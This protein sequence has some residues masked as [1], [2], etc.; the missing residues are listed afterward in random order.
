MQTEW[1]LFILALSNALYLFPQKPI[2]LFYGMIAIQ[3]FQLFLVWLLAQRSITNLRSK[4]FWAAYVISRVL[5]CFRGPILEDDYFRYL[6]DGQVLNLGINPYLYAPIDVHL[7]SVVS[8]WRDR[9]NFPKVKT[10][11]PPVAQIYFAI[12]FLSFGE[13]I[14]G[15]RV[16]AVILELAV[17]CCLSLLCKR[18][19]RDQMPVLLFLFFPT[20]M[21][22]N[23]NSIHFDLLAT[24]FYLGAVLLII[25]D[26]RRFEIK[27]WIALGLS[28]LAKLFPL[29]LVPIFMKA[30]KQ[31][32]KAIAVLMIVIVAAYLPFL[33]AS[34]SLFSGTGAF[35]QN[36]IFFD[37]AHTA[38]QMILAQA[39]TIHWIPDSVSYDW[40][41]SGLVARVLC[42][43]SLLS[44]TIWLFFRRTV[45]AEQLAVATENILR[46][47]TALIMML[48][49]FSSVVNTWY[50]LWILPGM[51]LIAPR[52]TW[53]L[54]VLTTLGY[55]WFVSQ[56][57]YQKLHLP[58]YGIILFAAAMATHG[59]RA[60][61]PN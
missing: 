55:S 2:D 49:V 21:K 24:L 58:F 41:E 40:L 54:P 5:I 33:G 16:G 46:N 9:I 28:V 10:I 19:N 42:L 3:I 8:I 14:L 53:I 35:A 48:L 11:Y 22:E 39:Y 51:L 6:W 12:L 29:L 43:A 61:D 20:V 38:F 47:T 17:A 56:D 7:D 30:T 23:I 25:S 18:L 59:S 37:S 15:L 32:T 44:Y 36:W 57:L 52:W 60:H 31:P 45:N 4:I 1:I 13:S 26:S 50:W 34:N 27:G